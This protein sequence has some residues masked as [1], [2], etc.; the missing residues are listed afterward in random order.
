M[1]KKVLLVA[2]LFASS[3]A[4]AAPY[5]FN[6]QDPSQLDDFNV[7][8]FAFVT[9]NDDTLD[10]ALFDLTGSFTTGNKML[11]SSSPFALYN[12]TTQT[13]AGT[14]FTSLANNTYSFNFAG[15]SAGTYELRFNLP[16]GS[17]RNSPI[18]GSYSI[19]AVTAPVPEPETFALLMAGLGLLGM[20]ARKKSR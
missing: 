1:L 17:N 9:L 10:S 5:S 6:T 18:N 2:A 15:L 19:S 14:Q 11:V 20:V 8:S 3:S 13:V 4:F 12:T 16:G 7:G